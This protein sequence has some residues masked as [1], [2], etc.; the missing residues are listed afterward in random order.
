MRQPERREKKQKNEKWAGRK[1]CAGSTIDDP[2]KSG[3]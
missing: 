3:F 2:G 1:S